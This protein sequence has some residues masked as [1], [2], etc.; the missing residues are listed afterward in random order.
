MIYNLTGKR[1]FKTKLKVLVASFC[2][3]SIQDSLSGHDPTED[4]VA[5]MEL[6]LL[7]LKMGVEFGDVILSRDCEGVGEVR[8]FDFTELILRIL[9][10]LFYFIIIQGK[11]KEQ[12]Q[13]Q[14]RRVC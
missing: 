2:G 5:A 6:V 8:I 7:K 1:S 11:S 14:R 4:A 10:L 13:G 9:N 12:I 3:R